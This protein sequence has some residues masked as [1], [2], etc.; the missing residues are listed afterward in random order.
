[1]RILWDC[2]FKESVL[3]ISKSIASNASNVFG[4]SLELL[5]QRRQYGYNNMDL[6][7]VL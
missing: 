2:P 4:N 1:M 3:K 5:G 7:I 6:D